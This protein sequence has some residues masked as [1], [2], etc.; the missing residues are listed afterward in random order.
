[1]GTWEEIGQVLKEYSPPIVWKLFPDQTQTPCKVAECLKEHGSINS[2][3]GQFTAMCWTLAH[4]YR[5]MVGT[6]QHH[7]QSEGKD[8]GAGKPID[9]TSAQSPVT[10][11]G[12]SQTA[13]VAPVQR[14]KYKAKSIH[15][16]N[17]D[18]EPGRSQPVEDPEPEILT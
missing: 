14:K 9:I 4:A 3:D 18:R 12:K 15:P 5:T 7:L 8:S 13:E 17:E 2:R 6:V 10:P 1:M 11:E 16:V